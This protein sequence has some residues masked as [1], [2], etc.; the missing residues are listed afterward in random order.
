M[1]GALAIVETIML[2]EKVADLVQEAT[3]NGANKEKHEYGQAR[4]QRDK[5]GEKGDARR[6][7]NPNKRRPSS[8]SYSVDEKAVAAVTVAG[9][10]IAIVWVVGNNATGVGVADDAALAGLIPIFWTN[11]EI[12]NAY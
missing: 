2:A 11:I 7:P 8:N 5:S 12:L 4:K 3:D 1:L 6:K 10:G 9:V